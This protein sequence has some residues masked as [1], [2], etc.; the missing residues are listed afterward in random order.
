M[1]LEPCNLPPLGAL[2]SRVAMAAM[3]RG[4]AASGHL[5]TGDIAAYYGRRA[6]D[7]VGLILTEGTIIDLSGDGYNNVPHIETTEQAASWKPVIDR[8]QV[9]GGKIYSQLWH[10]G[11]ISHSD[12]TGG[13]PPVSSTDVAAEGHN[14]QNDKPFGEPHALTAYEM[15]AIHA[16]FRKAARN[17][18]DAGFDGVQLHMGHGYLIDQFL[19]SRV[20]DRTDTFGGS[21]QNRCRLAL[22]CLEQVIVEVGAEK[23]MVRISP[24]RNMGG[25]YDWPDLDEMLKYLIPAFDD[26]G[27]RALDISC[28]ASDYFQTSGRI[29]RMIR[30][31]WPHVLIG[32]ASLSKEQAEAELRDGWLDIVTWGRHILGNQNFVTRLRENRAIEMFESEMLSELK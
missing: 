5:A 19:D 12:Y 1:L 18:I 24:S 9:A 15:P 31:D 7:G 30:A 4:F 14:R 22:E 16:M 32:G 21:V 2:N 26:A 6:E 8:V 13:V 11:R 28:A 3:T 17:A 23:T 10:C 20:N 27:L 29:V 25:I